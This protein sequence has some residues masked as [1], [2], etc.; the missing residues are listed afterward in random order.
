MDPTLNLLPAAWSP[1]GTHIAF[2]AW[3]DADAS[4][5]GIY[6]AQSSDGG[7]FVR[8]TTRPGPLVDVPLDYSPDGKR[9]LFYRTAHPDP[10]PHIGG[11]LWTIRID[12]TDARQ[13]NGTAH[14]ADW[15]RWSPDGQRILFANERL[16][17]SGAL[18]TVAPDGSDLRQVFTDPSGGFPISPCWSPD[19]SRILFA[20]DPIND[21]FEHR[22]NVFV[23]I[24]A[25]GTHAERVAGTS[26]FSR[27][28]EWWK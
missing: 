28:P 15:A 26:G 21:E 4:R 19:G 12:G 22:D 16:S 27:W 2:L 20:L 13:I 18:W 9:L 10:D 23:V 8:V 11:S 6:S 3:D 5:T 1:D 24:D 25:D 17:A 14:P 7:D